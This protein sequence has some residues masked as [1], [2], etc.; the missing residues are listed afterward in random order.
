MPREQSLAGDGHVGG[1][2]MRWESKVPFAFH[3]NGIPELLDTCG[4]GFS[5]S[6]LVFGYVL[7]HWLQSNSPSNV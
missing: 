5:L 7:L 1:E 6:K 4:E 3:G 2:L